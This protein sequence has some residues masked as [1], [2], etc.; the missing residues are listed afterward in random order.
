M[1]AKKKNDPAN[2]PVISE[3]R[4][5]P[6][7]TEDAV[8]PPEDA[9]PPVQPED[10]LSVPEIEDPQPPNETDVLKDRL[11]RLQADFD[12]YRKR[13]AREYSE[14]RANA[15]KDLL[16]ALLT[17]IDHMDHVIASMLKITDKSD[18]FLQGVQ[19]VRTELK[20]ALERFGLKFMPTVGEVFNPELH[21]A[22][23]I[24]PSKDVEEGH[25]VAEV[26]TGYWLNN[27]VLRAAQVMVSQGKN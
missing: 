15:N 13:M 1:S 10:T 26:R 2:E 17:P 11:L 24:V 27:R 25:I 16:E 7:P 8:A 4:A 12:N 9:A 22:L 6:A 20:T 5:D 3:E 23:G 18:P 21:E 14:N 19:L